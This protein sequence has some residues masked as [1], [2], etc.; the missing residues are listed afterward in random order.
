[1]EALQRLLSLGAEVDGEGCAAGEGSGLL[2]RGEPGSGKTA[3]L[4]AVALVAA[5]EGR[6]PVLFVAR[7]ALQSLPPVWKA[8]AARDPL[9]LQKIH[10]LYPPSL[11]E[12]L[13]LLSSM[14]ERAAQPP[15]LLLLDGI[16]E[17]L[18]ETSGAQACAHLAALLVDTAAHFSGCSGSGCGLLVTMQ[19]P[20]EAELEAAALQLAVLQRYLPTCLWLE[21]EPPDLAGAWPQHS[22]QCFRA[23]LSSGPGFPKQ[24]WCLSFGHDGEMAIS[25]VSRQPSQHPPQKAESSSPS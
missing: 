18:A 20:A 16:D 24:E 23:R 17:Y 3:L 19:G 2:L 14:H 6:G 1:M 10:F 7:R 25:Q 11:R 8:G 9:R 5:G 4:F 21:P 15:S 13:Q 22:E 12:L